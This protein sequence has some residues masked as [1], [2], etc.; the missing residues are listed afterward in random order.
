MLDTAEKETRAH[1]EYLK[2]I[3]EY[4]AQAK[5]IKLTGAME[6]LQFYETP[7]PEPATAK[8]EA[9]KEGSIAAED[10][11][12]L[13]EILVEDPSDDEKDIIPW[14][15]EGACTHDDANSGAEAKGL[16]RRNGEGT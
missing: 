15:I 4:T 10:Q 9:Q 3:E 1:N 13:E 2:A 14:A 5:S 6:D 12:D 8:K 7:P 16:A 11:D